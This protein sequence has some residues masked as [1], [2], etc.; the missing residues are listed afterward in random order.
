[1]TK[2]TIILPEKAE[3]RF[4]LYAKNKTEMLIVRF[5]SEDCGIA[6]VDDSSHYQP[7][8]ENTSWVSCFNKSTW[9]ILPKGT[10]VHTNVTIETITV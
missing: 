5:D 9:E 1:M 3:S 7:M 4:P 2:T 10:V 8:E 6:I